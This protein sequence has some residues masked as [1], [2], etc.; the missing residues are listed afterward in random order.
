MQQ[1]KELLKNK[2]TKKQL[3]LMPSSFD[4][5][6]DILIF[7]DFPDE[8]HK[9]EKLIAKTIL[10]TLKNVKVI[11]KKTGK[12]AGKF[13]TPKIKII[14][15]QN[16]KETTYKENNVSLKLHIEKVYF[17]PRL[18]NERK[19]IANLVQANEKILVMF[20]G[21]SPYPCVIARNAKPKEI[22]GVEINPIA[23]KY[24]LV[25]VRQN[26]LTNVKLYLG[27][28]RKVVPKLKKKF[29][30]ILMPLPKGA[31]NFLDVALQA[32]RKGTIIHF[33]DF[34]P[35]NE[36]DLA[37]Q[38]ITGAC[39]KLRK[40]VIITNIIKCGRFSPSVFRICV[41]FEVI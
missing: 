19:R 23:H 37:K 32:A 33:Y 39:I 2:L 14:A 13:R 3:R 31:E 34:L 27:D 36:F 15:G 20:S 6:G 8:L 11:A 22:I 40:K 10:N 16:R 24:A 26:K 25:N 7:A 28:V 17:S 4:I 29:D 9:K 1:L 38:K 12:Y 18:G 30:R 41:D 35:E 5:V 21:C